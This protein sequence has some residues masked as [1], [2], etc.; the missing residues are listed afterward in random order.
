MPRTNE[1]EIAVWLCEQLNRMAEIG[2]HPFKEVSAETG[3]KNQGRTLFPDI[4][5]WK[6]RAA[7]EAFAYLEIKQ[8]GKIEDL[9]TFLE[10]ALNLRVKYGLTWNF[11]EA[12][13]YTFE[14]QKLNKVKSYSTY[15][16]IDISSWIGAD[17]KIRLRSHLDQF[18][19]DI[20]ELDRMGHLHDFIPDKHFF[21][22]LLQDSVYKLHTHYAEHL[23]LKIHDRELKYSIEQWATTQ[24]IANVGDENF[25]TTLSRQWAYRFISKLLFYRRNTTAVRP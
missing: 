21:V 12:V 24:G 19:T 22:K 2:A 25:Y 8:P 4:V 16:L 3:V 10:K 13:L 23:K 20:N 15:A 1:R 18:I 14:N 9:D 6:N 7:G 11:G 17:V 5:L